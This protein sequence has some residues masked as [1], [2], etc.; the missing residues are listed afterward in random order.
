MGLLVAIQPRID[1]GEPELLRLLL[2]LVG[3]V[4]RGHPF[5]RDVRGEGKKNLWL[6]WHG[7]LALG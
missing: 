3:V 5:G 2:E 1:H 4:V 7:W 6:N